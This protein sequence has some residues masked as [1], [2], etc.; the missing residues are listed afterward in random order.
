MR[1][2]VAQHRKAVDDGDYWSRT[3]LHW[4]LTELE[5]RA[6]NYEQARAYAEEGAELAAQS[7]DYALSMFLCCRA[8]V[9]AHTGDS[10]T[11]R[12][13][14]EESLVE[15]RAMPSEFF[16]VRPRIALAFLAVS[17]R[18]YADALQHLEGLPELALNGPY[19]ATYPFWGDL[20]DALVSLASS[21]ARV[22][23]S[24]TSTRTGMSSSDRGPRR[25]SRA[26]AA[27][28]WLPPG[29]SK[30]ASPRS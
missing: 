30:R 1:I 27:S 5:C 22:R 24:R 7:D 14:A 12:A 11:A 10:A 8:L 19:W 16:T 15:A 13:C 23:C 17:E 28:S 9:A 2:L 26:A 4:P 20:F 18:R 6:G 3:F 21:S 29:R 25:C